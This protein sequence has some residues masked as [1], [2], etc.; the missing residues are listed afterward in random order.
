MNKTVILTGASGFFGHYI[1][2]ELSRCGYAVVPVNHDQY[3][4]ISYQDCINSIG[5]IKASILVH[6]AARSGGIAYNKLYP[7][8]IF[9]DN[10]VMNL[11]VLKSAS[12][13]PNITNVLS[14]LS[15]CSYPDLPVLKEE[16]FWKGLPNESIEAF[17]CQKRTL[18]SYGRALQKTC[19]NK[20]FR[21]GVFNNLFG[22]GDSLDEVKTKFAMN[23]VKKVCDAHKNKLP[24]ITCWGDGSPKREL[25]YAANAAQ[26]IVAMLEAPKECPGLLNIVSTQAKELGIKEYTDIV[27][28]LV[29]YKGEVLWDTT[30]PNG[31]MRKKLDYTNCRKEL[32]NYVGTTSF[33]DGLLNTIRWYQNNG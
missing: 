4:L 29:E 12:L 26:G 14:V 6:C 5:L 8:K 7:D 22:P 1:H 19:T 10:T 23:I 32:P 18:V 15:S 30:K 11:N 13:N 2:R 9:Y 16:D 3:D 31:Q 33:T 25:E 28:D 24:S 21:C 20:V 17:G 27:V